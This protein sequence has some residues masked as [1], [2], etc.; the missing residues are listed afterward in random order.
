VAYALCQQAQPSS[1]VR[2]TGSVRRGSEGAA[3]AFLVLASLYAV[4]GVTTVPG[5]LPAAKQVGTLSECSFPA[6]VSGPAAVR[7][8]AP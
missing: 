3:L 7:V 2:T 1:Q 6:V 8:A 5:S 4:I